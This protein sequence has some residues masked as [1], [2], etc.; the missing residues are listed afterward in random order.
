MPKPGIACQL[1]TVRA[2]T[3]ADFP[4]AI[5]A[6]ADIGYRAVE[7][8]GYGSARTAGEARKVLSDHGMAVVGSHTNLE[9]LERNLPRLIEE[10]RALGNR[11]IVLSFLP[12]PRRTDAAGWR[13][14]AR[15]LDQIGATLRQ[16]GLELAYHHHHFEFQKFDGKYAL[17]ILWENSEPQNLKAE[18]DT[19]WIKYGGEDPAGYIARL[20]ART[21][22][23]HLKDMRTRPDRRFA[24]VGDGILAFPAI[25]AAAER[26]G[27]RWGIVEQDSTYDT[28]P[29]DAV[30]RS[31]EHLRHLGAV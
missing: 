18:L 19:F 20:G 11:T 25:L 13:S 26:A 31:F 6:V 12:E 16:Q 10:S 1:Y 21:P 29:L 3:H 23:L 9:N 17:D 15:L 5:K 22:L 28:P 27:V 30:R 2:L 14:A 4:G 24:E 7:L 8:A